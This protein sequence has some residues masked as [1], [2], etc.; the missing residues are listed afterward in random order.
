MTEVSCGGLV[1]ALR[2][3]TGWRIMWKGDCEL[4]FFNLA[5]ITTTVRNHTHIQSNFCAEINIK[6]H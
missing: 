5:C 6:K 3:G 1:E 2:I 4:L